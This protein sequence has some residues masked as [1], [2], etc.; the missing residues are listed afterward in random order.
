MT[1]YLLQKNARCPV[2]AGT[3]YTRTSKKHILFVCKNCL[4]KFV[5]IKEGQTE[6]EYTVEVLDG[7]FPDIK[8]TSYEEKSVESMYDYFNGGD[9]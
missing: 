4:T 7:P 2:C 9:K 1:R 3:L 6:G 5:P 8:D